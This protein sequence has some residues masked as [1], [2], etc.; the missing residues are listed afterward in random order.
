MSDPY[1]VLGIQRGATDDEIKKAYRN[2]SR[3]YHPDANINNPN[4]ELA[5]EKFKEVQQA[6][7]QIMKEKEQGYSSDPFGSYDGFG[8]FG[9]YGS[10]RAG[11]SEDEDTMYFRAAANYIQ[12]RHYHEA[13]N[14][15][16]NISS[17]N[18]QWYYYSSIANA[19]L[20]NNV[21]ALE[22]ARNAVE[23]E[24]NNRQYQ[25]L[26]QQLQMGGSWYQTQQTSYGY[27]PING[28]GICLKLCIVNMICN[29]C[30][31][32]GG[33]CYGGGMPTGGMR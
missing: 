5:E 17:R 9:G 16:T 1:Q 32:G 26:L 20:G 3:R 10:Q 27:E 31:G 6:Y 2:L 21:I 8:E 7:S 24:P 22:H 14:V 25:A 11:A 29:L 33:L 4:K 23:K 19:G 30:C 18:G 28:N 15:L 12:S 13:L